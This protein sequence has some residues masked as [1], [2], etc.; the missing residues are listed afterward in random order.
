MEKRQTLLSD[1]I[2]SSTRA[3]AQEVVK[4]WHIE[5]PR[6][7]VIP[8]SVDLSR[9][10]RLAKAKSAPETLTNKEFLL[11]F[12]RLEERKG[13]HVLADA[14]PAVFKE[15]PHLSMAFVGADLGYQGHSM[16][17]YIAN[18]ASEYTDRLFFFDNL[19]QADLFP[20]VDLA[21][22]VILPS[23]WEAF[24]FVCIEAMALGCPVIA[25]SGSGFEEIIEDNVSGYLVEPGD[26]IALEE[27]IITTL[28]DRQNL[29]RISNGAEQRAKAFD[30]HKICHDLIEYY[31]RVRENWLSKNRNQ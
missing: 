25:T 11:Y 3:L 19:P 9:L 23:L 22:L 13:V 17:E 21:K 7:E 26:R 24:G 6:I 14:L 16:R 12:G 20:I 8:N 4:K 5:R 1:G 28:K 18:S 29:L 30:V 31:S 10:I 2:F 27:K 15:F